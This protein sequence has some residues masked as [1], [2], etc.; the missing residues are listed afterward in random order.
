MHIHTH[1]FVCVRVYIRLQR[2]KKLQRK[3]VA[4]MRQMRKLQL[5][6]TVP[7][8]PNKNTFGL[9]KLASSLVCAY[10]SFYFIGSRE[11][12]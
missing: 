8:A 3:H 2:L 4:K 5:S 9:N 10:V 1:K 7:I 6:K 12:Q 11:E